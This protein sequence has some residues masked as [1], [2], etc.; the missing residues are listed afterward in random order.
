MATAHT[1]TLFPGLKIVILNWNLKEDTLACVDSILKAGISAGQIIL[2][3]NGSSDGS[4]DAFQTRYTGQMSLMANTHNI[5]YVAG[6]NQ[7]IKIAL[8]QGAEWILLL[9][10]DTV[11]A[12]DFFHQVHSHLSH[13]NDYGIFGPLIY[14]FSE[15]ER[16]W[17]TGSRLVRGTLLTYDLSRQKKRAENWPE[18]LPVDFVSGCAMFVHRDVFIRVGLFDPYLVMYGE[19]V[20]FCWRARL[21]G[22]RAACLPQVKMWHKVSLSANR[23]RAQTRYLRIRNQSIFYRRYGRGLQRPAMFLYGFLRTA[24][25]MLASLLNGQIELITPTWYGFADGWMRTIGEPS[26]RF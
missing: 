7:G 10:N 25:M 26:R 9:N 22:F 6:V 24:W 17:F 12:E 5:G 18:I 2:I 20:D 1:P 3:D 14:Y 21:A 13:S 19:E 4:V 11:V 23:V 16:V 8:E 15:P